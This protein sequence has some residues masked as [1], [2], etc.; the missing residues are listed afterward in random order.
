MYKHSTK[1]GCSFPEYTKAMKRKV[2]QKVEVWELIKGIS[3]LHTASLLLHILVWKSTSAERCPVKGKKKSHICTFLLGIK[4]FNIFIFTVLNLLRALILL[5]RSHFSRVQL[6]ATPDPR[7]QPTRLPHPWD[8]SGKNTGVGCHFLL[9][10]MKVKSLSR[11]Q[12]LATPWT[13]AYKAPLVHGIFQARVLEWGAIAF[14]VRALISLPQQ[15]SD[16]TLL[17]SALQNTQ[18]HYLV[19]PKFTQ[20][21]KSFYTVLR[22]QKMLR[23]EGEEF[24]SDGLVNGNSRNCWKA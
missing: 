20:D 13:A 24:R 3:F 2:T 23:K 22:T 11:V 1:D 19:L 18:R 16:Y 5:L 21:I 7:W 15:Y 9:Q 6:W 14:S 10:C 4:F 12:L 8:S 17:I